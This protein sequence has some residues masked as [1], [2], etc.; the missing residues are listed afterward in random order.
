MIPI[1]KH[2]SGVQRLA[3]KTEVSD[4]RR[5]L[6][7][8]SDEVM[9]FLRDLSE[10]FLKER[11]FPELVALGFW[12]RVGNLNTIKSTIFNSEEKQTLVKPL[13][14]VA[15]FTPA[16][17][18]TMFI[19]SWVCSLLM[20]NQNIVR[21]SRQ[22][23]DLKNRILSEINRLYAMPQY[24]CLAANNVFITYE[25]DQQINAAI[26][27]SADARVLWGGDSSVNAIRDFPCKPN[28]R[29][30]A[31]ADRYSVALI[32]GDTLNSGPSLKQAIDAMVRDLLPYEQ[33]ACSS[34]KAVFWLGKGEAKE[35][36]F[37]GIN[38]ALQTLPNAPGRRNEMLVMEQMAC[39][40]DDIKDVRHLSHLSL[41]QVAW[42]SESLLEYHPGQRCL[43]LVDIDC[44]DDLFS[45]IGERCQT[46]SYLG[47]EHETLLNVLSQP[48]ITSIDR[49]VKVGQALDFDVLWDGYDCLSQLSR[50]VTIR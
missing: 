50:K 13:G 42:L 48:S 27:A 15:H 47:V 4:Q 2:L 5:L 37:Q 31:F 1:L 41:L 39:I 43:Y 10:A 9:V 23:T 24:H 3:P 36:F 33:Q 25:H 12:L 19:Y 20:G 18:D 6:L 22:N 46:L 30:I 49:C 7:P 21:L 8:F 17:V 16:N 11:D 29:D 45:S 26:C 32:N 44:L 38:D 28:C 14:L 40:N 34:P 35:A